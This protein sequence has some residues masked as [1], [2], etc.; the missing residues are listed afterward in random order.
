VRFPPFNP[1]I[2]VVIG[3]ISISTSA[4]LVKLA[5]QAPAAIIANYRLLFAV[6]IMAPYALIRYRSE[7]KL[8]QKKDKLILKYKKQKLLVN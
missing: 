2:A 4:V 7:L 3:V 5:N 8:I 6:L 1:Y